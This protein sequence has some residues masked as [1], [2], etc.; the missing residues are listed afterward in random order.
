VGNGSLLV[1]FDHQYR[2]RDLYWPHV[3]QENHTVGHPF[4]FGVWVDGAF[5]WVSDSGWER[6]LDYVGDTLVTEVTLRHPELGI[7][8]ICQ[9]AVD[10]HENLFV[11]RIDV[12]DEVGRDR[13]VRLFF[14]QDFHISGNQVGD[15]AYYEPERRAVLHYKNKR[16]FMINTTKKG[17]TLLPEAPAVRGSATPEGDDGYPRRPE[18]QVRLGVD[19]WA[20][21]IKEARGK[22]GTWRDAED[23]ELSGNAVAQ[24]S[25]DSTVALHLDVPADG[26]ATGWYWIAVGD[27]FQEVTRLNRAVRRKT[28]QEFLKRTGN[29]WKLWITKEER[30]LADLPPAVCHLYRRSLAILRTQIDN[31]GAILA[32]NDFDIT[33]YGHDTYAYM[34]PR[35]G[36]LVSV[37]LIGS[38][39]S[40]VTRRFF[41]FCHRVITE[42]G[43]LLHKYNSDGSLASSWHGWYYRGEKQLPIQEDE[44]A[45]VLWALWRHFETFRDVEFIKSHYRGLI[46]RAANWMCRYRHEESGLPLPSWDL[47]EERHG[48]HA[49]TVGAVWAGLQAAANFS[50]AFGETALVER[51]RTVA[52]EIKAGAE[53]HLW[54]PDLGRFVRTIER[55]QAGAWK[56]DATV[57]ASMVGLWKFGM[58]APDHPKIVATMEQ[59]RERLWVKT[60]VGGLARYENDTYH[61]VSKD[62]DEV[63]GNPWFICTLWLAQWYTAAAQNA[64]QLDAALDLLGWVADH[65]LRSGVMAEQVD[66]YTNEP[67]SVSPLTWSHATLVIAVLE[68]LDTWGRMNRCPECGHP[69]TAGGAARTLT[70]SAPQTLLD[71]EEND[72]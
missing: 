19:Q 47:W 58:F 52:E 64:D 69:M 5:R 1:N 68:Y 61:Q 72:A 27:S 71:T 14:G 30:R 29:Y 6:T 11:R 32:A 16:W 8:L 70:W 67:L 3:G 66:P 55:G 31:D 59:V 15:T 28:P 53:R 35:D 21:G 51:Y 56:A 49:W 17:A 40:E 2:L 37:A 23:G 62:L 22:E 54:S 60:D 39:Y 33:H 41:N 20:V 26:H 57:D 48:V 65:D 9:D 36:A 34:W 24:G 13:G 12:R 7:Q 10:F 45:L 43:Y 18:A 50:E 42:E 38:G 63:P 46:S 25:V 4:R 44:T